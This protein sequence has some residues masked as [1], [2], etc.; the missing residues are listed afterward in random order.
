MGDKNSIRSYIGP[1]GWLPFAVMLTLLGAVFCLIMALYVPAAAVDTSVEPSFFDPR[2]ESAQSR[3]YVDI[4]GI[5]E[6][7]VRE[8]GGAYFVA[9]SASYEY[10]LVCLPE[11]RLELL[12]GQ[13]DYWDG[14]SSFSLPFRLTGSSAPIPASVEKTICDIF[15][16]S[17]ETFDANFGTL[18]FFDA[19]TPPRPE[20]AVPRLVFLIPGLILAPAFVLLLLWLLLRLSTVANALVRLEDEDEIAAAAGELEAAETELADG[21]R[22]RVGKRFLFGWRNGLAARWEDVQ[23]CRERIFPAPSFALRR[24]L[25]I[26]TADGK[27]HRVVF[28]ADAKKEIAALLR[29]FAEKNPKLEQ[30]E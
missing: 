23:W 15:E 18:C 24:L 8:G 17:A 9:E 28:P 14:V 13:R 30:K 26:G 6:P 21:D 7:L 16:M 10:C 27:K 11:S 29:Q 12:A 5:S 20:G 4:L 1:G 19:D 22:L 2:A 3:A 25:V